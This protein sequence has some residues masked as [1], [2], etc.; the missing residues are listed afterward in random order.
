MIKKREIKYTPF[1][2]KLAEWL[3]PGVMVNA[4]DTK[5]GGD[6]HV[7]VM[8]VVSFDLFP[9]GLEVPGMDHEK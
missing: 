9:H 7:V 8:A 2:L 4:V 3:A 6:H 1:V 5:S